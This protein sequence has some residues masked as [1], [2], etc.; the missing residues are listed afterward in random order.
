VASFSIPLEVVGV[1]A[2]LEAV[3]EFPNV[4]DVQALNPVSA[5][6]PGNVIGK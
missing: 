6:S 1:L 5:W 3:I 2:T 4:N